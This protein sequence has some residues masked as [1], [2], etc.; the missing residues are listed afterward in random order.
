MSMLTREFNYM[1]KAQRVDIPLLVRVDGKTYT[2]ADWSMTGLGII[3]F[4]DAVTVGDSQKMMLVLPVVGASLHIET[5]AVCRNIRGNITGFE[6]IDLP[7]RHKRVLRH[8]V[9]LSLEGKLDS[10]EDLLS[11]FTAPDIDSPIKE[12]LNIS[13]EEQVSLLRKFR[14][15]AF[16]SASA[17]FLLMGYIIFTL[18]YNTIF[19]YETIGVASGNLVQ[20]TAGAT[21]VLKQHRVKVGDQIRENDIL[22]DLEDTRL[23]ETLEKN[24][25][26]IR[27]QTS[28]LEQTDAQQQQSVASE[29]LRLLEEELA[30]KEKEYRNASRLYA[31]NVISIKDYQFIEGEF[32]RARINAVREREQQQT[33][34]RNL[35]ERKSL[36]QMK[37]DVLYDER[38]R[39]L[40]N[41][42]SVRIKSPISGVVFTIS[43]FSGEYLNPNDVVVTLATA[44]NPFI[45]FKMP[46]KQS[47]KAQLGMKAKIHS[48]ETGRTYEGTISSIG[49][50]AI[51]PRSTLLQEVSLDQT[52][53][54]VDLQGDNVDIPLNSRVNVW[55]SK[56]I[57]YAGGVL[58]TLKGWFGG[59]DAE[60]VR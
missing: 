39:L 9:E 50:S 10:V 17:G 14:S 12:A 52:V 26:E 58:D 46:S 40:K 56:E 35:E 2:T 1:R 20:I 42:E 18:I 31:D 13:E 49:Y 27:Q 44:E 54:K 21:G 25:E 30:R 43:F 5:K 60:T 38:K 57:P 24:G 45:L 22:F 55:I 51:N 7:A 33:G 47:G 28:L 32:N 36:I 16:L 37:I 8:Y 3:D 41:L 59:D 23:V 19:T 53:I 48:F 29:L 34:R 6:F 4:H 15:R 11:D